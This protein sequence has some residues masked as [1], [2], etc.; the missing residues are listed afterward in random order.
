MMS[1]HDRALEDLLHNGDLGD[2]AEG[3]ELCV[4]AAGL[5]EGAAADNVS[6]KTGRDYESVWM[7]SKVL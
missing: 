1:P 3:A 2:E 7:F 4:A 6:M 5:R